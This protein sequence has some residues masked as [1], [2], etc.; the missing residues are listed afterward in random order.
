MTKQEIIDLMNR[1]YPTLPDYHGCDGLKAGA[2]DEE[3]TGV[4]CAISPTAAVIDETIK[5]GCNLLIVHEPTFYTSAD[6]PL[7]SAPFGNEIYEIKKERLHQHHI[8]VWRNHD[9][10]HMH[11]PD[12]IFT[13]LI[14]WLGWQ[15]YQVDN[16]DGCPFV[17]TFEIPKTTVFE[18]KCFLEKKLNLNGMRYMGLPEGEI[19]KIAVVGHLFPNAFGDEHGKVMDYPT[20]IIKV[21]EKSVDAIIPGE[22]VEWTVLSYIRDALTFGKNKALFNVGHFSL[23][24]PGMW[25]ITQILSDLIGKAVPVHFVSAGDIFQF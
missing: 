17:Y 3:C 12:D 15:D 7:W 4:V 24:E 14:R 23:E 18:M 22:V 8:T 6:T 21:L 5:K 20:Q 19:R 11:R 25:Y 1:R 10:M 13:G 16:M 2:L 9:R